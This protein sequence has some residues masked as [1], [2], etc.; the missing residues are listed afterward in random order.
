MPL[1]HV[2]SSSFSSPQ[3]V[4]TGQVLLFPV[5]LSI[6]SYKII[7]AT[8]NIWIGYKNTLIYTGIGVLITL[9]LQ[10]TAGY[11]FS[12]KG[13]K[14]KGP[15]TFFYVLTMFLSG[16][17]IPTYLVVQQ[18]GMLDTIWAIIIPG[19]FGVFNAIIVRTYINSMIP[20]EVQESAK[21]DGC[22]PMRTFALIIIPL[23]VPI[24]AVTT[25]FAVV[26]YWNSYFNALLYVTDNSKQPLQ[27]VIQKILIQTDANDL[28]L[29]GG[30]GGGEAAI[31]SE[32]IKYSVI[33]VASLPILVIYPF[34]EKYFDKG[35]VMGSLKG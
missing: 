24:L 9:T 10:F 11:A 18:L 5:D 19:S 27:L 23:C 31:L 21:M 33:I 22:G 15:I 30:I 26:G 2:L 8:K 4:Y 20:Y 16:G 7:F 13:L 3:A 6:E 1:M 28:G 25:L 35:M 29:D 17:M 12:V 32:S 14:L 34:F